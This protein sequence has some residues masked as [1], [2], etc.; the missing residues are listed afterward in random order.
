MTSLVKLLAKT[1]FIW[2]PKMFRNNIFSTT[3]A[4]TNN[5]NTEAND[6]GV[7]LDHHGATVEN[8]WIMLYKL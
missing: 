5:C 1:N 2:F 8:T 3:L 4:K 7:L 6:G